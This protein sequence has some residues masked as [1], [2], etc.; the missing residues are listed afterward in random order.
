[1]TAW[2]VGDPVH[3]RP[4]G[5][6]SGTPEIGCAAEISKDGRRV[7]VALTDGDRWFYTSTGFSCGK[8]SCDFKI[9]KPTPKHYYDDLRRKMGNELRKL[10]A[11]GIDDT[12]LETMRKALD[13]LRGAK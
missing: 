3:F 11:Q 1:M 8:A 5:Y 2:S 6:R 13:A 7:K 10:E 12:V 9:E 4:I